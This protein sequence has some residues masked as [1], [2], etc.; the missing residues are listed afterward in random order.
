MIDLRTVGARIADVV[1]RSFA[2]AVVVVAVVFMAAPVL[3]VIVLSFSNLDF[4]QFPPS[5]WGLRQYTQLGTAT[6]WLEATKQSFLV[7]LPTALLA[8]VV[9]VPAVIALYRTTV[10]GQSVLAF[11]A[12]VPL[13][14]PHVAYAVGMYGIMADANLIATRTGIVLSHVAIT[15]PLVFLIASA[16]ILRIPQELE[17]AAMSLGASRYRAW[18]GITLRLLASAVGA[19]ALLAFVTSFD[20]PVF[21]SFLGGPGLVTLPKAIFDSVLLGVDPVITAI[22][23]ILIV[24]TAL[25]IV[26]A[27]WLQRRQ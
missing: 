1:V 5:E 12:I 4:I 3:V 20:E 25:V 16:S 19:G 27:N 24:S 7:A 15:F 6:E 13:L 2:R 9:A 26:L 8:I 11:A 21:A 17:L 22:A 23:T 10:R 14:I 18:L